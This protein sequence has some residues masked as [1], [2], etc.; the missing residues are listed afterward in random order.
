MALYDQ[1]RVE[2]AAR[3]IDDVPVFEE[4]SGE[5]ALAVLNLL[6]CVDV[7]SGHY[8]R[9]LAR[10][11][12]WS[13]RGQGGDGLLAWGDTLATLGRAEQAAAA[14]RLVIERDPESYAAALARER[15]G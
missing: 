1:G 2:E 9:A 6:V 10:R 15:L 12:A 5:F 4:P 7:A 13:L 11:A 14:W 8:A 3:A